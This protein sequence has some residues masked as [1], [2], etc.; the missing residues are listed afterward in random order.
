MARSTS[1]ARFSRAHRKGARASLRS[2]DF[3]FRSDADGLLKR[4]ESVVVRRA[5]NG[6]SWFGNKIEALDFAQEARLEIAQ[7]P[8]AV[9][10]PDPKYIHRVITNAIYQYARSEHRGMKLLSPGRGRWADHNPGTDGDQRR[11][12]VR[13]WVSTLP[14]RLREIYHLVYECR[15]DQRSVAAALR[16]TQPRISKL[17]RELVERGRRELPFFMQF[18]AA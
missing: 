17:N 16:L 6:A 3:V 11:A 10:T 12:M 5:A 1:G 18:V 13:A 9:A 2:N 15:A 4:W 7:I 8:A 14:P